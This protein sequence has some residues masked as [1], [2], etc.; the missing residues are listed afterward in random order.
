MQITN[1]H[2]I[3]WELNCSEINDATPIDLRIWITYVESGGNPNVRIFGIPLIL[4][5]LHDLTFYDDQLPFFSKLIQLLLA[6]GVDPNQKLD[7]LSF[8]EE[9]NLLPFDTFNDVSCLHV[10]YLNW[11][12]NEWDEKNDT[13]LEELFEKLIVNPTVNIRDTFTEHYRTR[14]S[15]WESEMEPYGPLESYRLNKHKPLNHLLEGAN[16]LHYACL[17]RDKLT[18]QKL[19]LRD[20]DLIHTQCSSYIGKNLISFEIDSFKISQK[21]EISYCKLEWPEE[22]EDDCIFSFSPS[23]KIIIQRVSNV[24]PL[25]IAARTADEGTC[26]LLIGHNAYCGAQDT[27]G[28]TPL[29]YFIEVDDGWGMVE[30]SER[31]I[32][33]EFKDIK[34]LK[35]ILSY[36]PP[37][38]R[39]LPQ[40]T[41]M[42][43]KKLYSICFDIRNRIPIYVYECLKRSDLVK[44]VDTKKYGF[45]QDKAIHKLHKYSNTDY[46]HSGYDKGHGAAAA[47]YGN[48][49]AKKGTYLLTNAFPQNHELNNGPWK[50][51]ENLIRDLITNNLC[52]EVFTGTLFTP[53]ICDDGKKRIVYEVIGANNIAVPTELFKVIFVHGH[54]GGIKTL[55]CRMRNEIPTGNDIGHAWTTVEKIQIASGLPFSGWKAQ[56]TNLV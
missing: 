19:I 2:H 16:L 46:A 33:L 6:K 26:G 40:P 35:K 29:N 43:H 20:S 12:L 14:F 49:E 31:K 56:R 23:L 17:I 50:Q 1:F 7:S 10:L 36:I 25:H 51:L 45:T 24:T 13:I 3:P 41:I 9:D 22:S 48:P 11:K 21:K 54:N 34:G 37:L 32:N 5:L 18:I 4:N 27:N 15:D 42:L 8:F 44:H 55:A 38:P 47:N 52:V 30:L 53:E 28:L 39:H